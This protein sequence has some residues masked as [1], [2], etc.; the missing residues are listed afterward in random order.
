ME[1]P[2]SNDNFT[3]MGR[4][5]NYIFMTSQEFLEIGAGVWEIIIRNSG[6]TSPS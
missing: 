6:G 4:N 3:V 5:D 1:H 2:L